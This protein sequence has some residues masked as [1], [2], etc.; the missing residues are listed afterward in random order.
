MSQTA[1]YNVLEGKLHKG[2]N[3]IIKVLDTTNT[4]SVKLNYQVVKKALVPVPSEHLKGDITTD[5]P[6]QFKDERGYLELETKREMKIDRAKLKF[7]KRLDYGKYKNAYMIEVLPDN[8]RSKTTVIYHPDIAAV[9][10][11]KVV[12]TFISDIPLLNGYEIAAELKK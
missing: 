8:K 5:L 10:W 9:G 3:V 1:Y 12:I 2:G 11:A 7:V 6:Y 4:F